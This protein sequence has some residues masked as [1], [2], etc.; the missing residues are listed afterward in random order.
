MHVRELL[1]HTSHVAWWGTMLQVLD[2]ATTAT[3]LAIVVLSTTPIV[4]VVPAPV[5]AAQRTSFTA[6]VTTSPHTTSPTSLT[7]VERGPAA[8]GTAGPAGPERLAMWLE[9]GSAEACQSS[10]NKCCSGTS[11]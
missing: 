11:A 8:V 5:V 6:L 3:A 4:L 9:V 10:Y 2:V 7:A 1:V